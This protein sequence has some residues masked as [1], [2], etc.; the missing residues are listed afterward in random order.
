MDILRG[1]A[2]LGIL[3][4]NLPLYVAPPDAF[5]KWQS[6]IWWTAL[7][8]QLTLLATAI[9]VQGKFYTLFS[10]LF[11][12]GFGLQQGLAASTAD[13]PE[14][15]LHY[16]R[17]LLV[18]FCFGLAHFY[19]LWWGDVLSIYAVLGFLLLRFREAS[20]ERLLRW[21]VAL[22]IVPLIASLGV[23]TASHTRADQ[24]KERQTR[25]AELVWSNRELHEDVRIMRSGT[26]LEI[27]R[28]RVRQTAS[29]WTTNAG[30]SIELFANFLLG[31]W[32]TRAGILQWPLVHRFLLRRVFL[33]GFPTGLALSAYCNF[34]FWRRAG[35]EQ[36][37][38]V[39]Y[40][41]ALNEFAARPLYAFGLAAGIV[42]LLGIRERKIRW[43]TP[44]QAAGRLA[45][46]NYL[47]ASLVWT[48]VANSYGLGLYGK[49]N[50]LTGLA[51]IVIFFAM[52]AAF[53]LLWL[54][55]FRVGP[56]EWLW[57]VLTYGSRVPIRRA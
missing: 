22:M 40:C 53:S 15:L 24:E 11:G 56:V 33:I 23:I 43:A 39:D 30:W 50:P 27:L 17:R 16:H 2:L 35:A 4:V 41:R 34:T 25:A 51:C 10:F 42:L 29:H 20:G 54:R 57:R 37:L 7:P 36:S 6:Q 3:F 21:A 49:I 18:L 26:Y 55:Y 5:F 45:L 31:L 47:M 9:L 46:T 38:F 48:T 1:I 32:V 13:T 12:V 44:F 19:L 52:Q 28:H 8:D 14:V